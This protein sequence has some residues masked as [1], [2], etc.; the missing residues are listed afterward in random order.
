M[1]FFFANPYIQLLRV[2]HWFKNLFLLLGVFVAAWYVRIDWLQ[3]EVLAKILGALL[4]ASLVSAANYVI[5]QLADYRYD[6]LH[7][8]KKERP[9]PSGKVSIRNSIFIIFMLI[10][11]SF[12]L[13]YI[14]FSNEFLITLICFG[15]A[16]IF[17]NIA[18]IRLKDIPYVDVLAESINNPIRFLLGWFVL[19]QVTLPSFSILLLAWSVG[20]ILMTAKRYDELLFFGKKLI[21]YRATFSKYSLQSLRV[22][23]YL[24]SVIS[25]VLFMLVSFE[26]RPVLL[27]SWPF[28]LI[29]LF[30]LDRKIITGQAKARLIEKF[31]LTQKFILFTFLLLFLITI[32]VFS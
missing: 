18:P 21:P 22:M 25:A 27:F 5:N 11:I 8:S 26:R 30:W 10:F 1:K 13:A 31:V 17:Y 28:L 20:A 19:L 15:L 6:F 24:Y 32:L 2:N 3:I 12:S 14:F 9:I 16:G 23:L 7:E 29:Y 4:I